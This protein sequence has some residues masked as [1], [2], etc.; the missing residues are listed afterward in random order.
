VDSASNGASTVRA[1]GEQDKYHYITALDENQWKRRRVIK[2]GRKKRYRYG[3]ANLRE[4]LFEMVDSK[5]KGYLLEVRAIFIEWD[6]GKCTVLITSL[7]A[8]VV[9]TS[10]VVKAFFDRSPCEQL[11]RG[12]FWRRPHWRGHLRLGS[13]QADPGAGST[14]L[15]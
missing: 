10:L 7:P 11:Q 5:E 6:H 15:C 14:R 4:C 8:E 9:E 13:A 12:I 3:A 1:F 2:E